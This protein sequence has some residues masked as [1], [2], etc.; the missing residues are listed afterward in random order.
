VLA[1]PT[2]T[3]PGVAVLLEA[4]QHIGTSAYLLGSFLLIDRVADRKI[5]LCSTGRTC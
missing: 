1:A 3:G 2:V 5:L 4:P